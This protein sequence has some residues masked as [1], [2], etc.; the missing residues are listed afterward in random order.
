MLKM[1][2]VWFEVLRDTSINGILPTAFDGEVM[3]TLIDE[4][5][6]WSARIKTMQ[7]EI[8]LIQRKNVSEST[9]IFFIN[10]CSR[11]SNF[12]I[13]LSECR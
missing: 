13:I 6:M 12:L 5:N 4:R 2:E 8:M 10:K 9:F 3:G 7:E 11:M 1:G